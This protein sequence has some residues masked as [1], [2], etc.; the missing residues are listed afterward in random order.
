MR[1]HDPSSL[2]TSSTKNE[3]TNSGLKLFKGK[4]THTRTSPSLH[5]FKYSFFQIWLDVEQT[6]LIDKIS[7]FWSREKNNLVC[8][9]RENYLPN[10]TVENN[11]IHQQVCKKIKSQT[12]KN[13]D[14]NVY[15]LAS[16]SLSLI[17]I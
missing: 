7:R 10:K 6:G 12:N 11:S 2:H 16:L 3:K 14:G 17:H 8:F 1:N 4:V 15:L 5:K 9:K 13:F